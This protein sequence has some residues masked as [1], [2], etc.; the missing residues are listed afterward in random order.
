MDY[1]GGSLTK[2]CSSTYWKLKKEKVFLCIKINRE[3]YH[4][5]RSEDSILL[6]CQLS[7]HPMQFNQS[8]SRLLCID[9]QI[10]SKVCMEIQRA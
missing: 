1:L 9:W 8:F 10:T 5:Y 4:I 2:M 3:M 7:P 6:R